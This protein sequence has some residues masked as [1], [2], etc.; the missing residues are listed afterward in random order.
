MEDD[1]SRIAD[2]SYVIIL[3]F[4]VKKLKLKGADLMI[5]A[6]IHGY[7]VGDNGC[8][9]GGLKY[10]M[11]W[12]GSSKPT[13]IRSLQWLVEMGYIER[14]D[15]EVYGATRPIYK[16]I[17]MDE[18]D[19]G[20]INEEFTGSN[21]NEMGGAFVL[22]GGN[23]SENGEVKQLNQDGKTNLPNNKYIDKC[24]D[25]KLD[26]K[27]DNI[28][29]KPSLTE[30]DE[31]F[32][33]LWEKYPRKKGRKDAQRHYVSARKKGTSYADVSKGLDRYIG[34]INDND[35]QEKYIKHGSAWFQQHSWEDDYP[36]TFEEVL[37][38]A[39]GT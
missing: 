14:T 20:G 26:T 6:I 11:E 8:Y 3:P 30:F 19:E 1:K 21:K 27:N 5:Y 15:Y 7:S 4:M 34:Y 38:R 37:K 29:V 10:L 12:T 23:F 25:N 16:T 33:T 24:L 13:V 36:E 2:N 17:N 39:L 32:K 35:I 22:P 31:E 9:W 18:N 28:L